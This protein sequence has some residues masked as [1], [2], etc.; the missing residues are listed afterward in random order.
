MKFPIYLNQADSGSFSGFVPYITGVFFAGATIDDAI[1]DA[2]SAIDAHLDFVTEYGGPVPEAKKIT[3]HLHDED[4]QNGFWAFID[5]DLSKYD[6]K[7]VKL[8]ITLPQNL[9]VKIDQYV[10]S[11]REYGS[12]SGFLADLARREL[13]KSV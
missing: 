13:Q 12:R 8:N 4:C 11:H 3:A 7:A 2:Y 10:E 6:G 5:I 1:N 9:L